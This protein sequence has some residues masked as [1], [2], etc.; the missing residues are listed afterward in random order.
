MALKDEGFAGDKCI[1]LHQIT[2]AF[3]AAYSLISHP[4][5]SVCCCADKQMLENLSW[6]LVIGSKYI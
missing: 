2:A 5:N 4:E 3:S 6:I 1:T